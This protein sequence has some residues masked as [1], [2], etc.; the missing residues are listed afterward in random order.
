[1]KGIVYVLLT[2]LVFEVYMT[3]CSLHQEC[4]TYFQVVLSGCEILAQAI[5]SD[6][7]CNSND[8]KGEI[9]LLVRISN[10]CF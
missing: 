10:K 2:S 7:R 1:M 3:L 5:T 6:Y 9:I 8:K 4:V